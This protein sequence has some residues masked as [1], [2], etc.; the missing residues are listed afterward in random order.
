MPIRCE[1]CQTQ[2]ASLMTSRVYPCLSSHWSWRRRCSG[3]LQRLARDADARRSRSSIWRMAHI[4]VLV[5]GDIH[6]RASTRMLLRR[7]LCEEI[8]VT[9]IAGRHPQIG[10]SGWEH[11]QRGSF[12]CGQG[13]FLCVLV[14]RA[15]IRYR[16]SRQRLCDFW[17]RSRRQVR[18]VSEPLSEGDKRVKC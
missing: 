15:R 17:R 18:S 1:G 3:Q 14:L 7:E 16:C 6:I 5:K 2:R 12:L 10:N 8:L 4:F 11:T 9:R 13:Q